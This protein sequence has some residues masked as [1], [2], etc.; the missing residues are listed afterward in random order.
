MKEAVAGRADATTMADDFR[1]RTW[2][3]T[4]P[5]EE[6][7]A[8]RW[9]IGPMAVYAHR[10]R[11]EWRVVFSTVGPALDQTLETM[12]SCSPDDLPDVED[13]V[14]FGFLRSPPAIRLE[15]VPA[16]RSVVLRPERTLLVPQG[17]AVEIFVSTPLW[18]RV[19]FAAVDTPDERARRPEPSVAHE[20]PLY[21]PSDTWFGPSPMEGE[22][23]YANRTH[24]FLSL[25]E[26][27]RYPH[28]ARTIVHVRNRGEDVLRVDRLNVPVR[29]LSL[30][31][32]EDRSLWTERV[33]LT[34]DADGDMAAMR[35]GAGAPREVRGASKVIEPRDRMEMNVVVRAFEAF[36]KEKDR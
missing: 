15:P 30:F 8:A 32:A 27:Q 28:R 21:R 34:R 2:W 33:T 10:R 31:M 29:H 23:C 11:H 35:V 4:F 7:A 5:L 19:S 22:L 9:R 14:R 1:E 36:F 18:L 16:D 26:V 25:E 24:A 12:R 6:G 13:A 17:D 3:G 20:V